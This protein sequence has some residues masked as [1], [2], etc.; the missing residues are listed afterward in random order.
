MRSVLVTGA[1][2]PLGSRLLEELRRREGVERIVGVEP[3]AT[4]NWIDGVELVAFDSDHRELFEFISIHEIDTVI[5]CALAPDR[6]GG[7]SEPAPARVIE[8]MRLGAAVAHEGSPVRAWVVA[9]SS[10]VY[11]ISSHAPLLHREDSALDVREGTLAA[12]LIEAEDY[13][14][15][16]AERNPHL[17]VSILRLQQLVGGGV[18]SPIATLLDQRILPAVIGYDAPMQVLAIDDA[19][20]ALI[21]AA[22]FELA[23][24]YNV[25]SAGVLRYSEARR[26]MKRR[27]LP[28]LPISAG[29]LGPLAQRVGIPHVPEGLL[30]RLLY[31]QA[32]DTS[33]LAA[34]G[35]DPEFDQPACLET[36][37]N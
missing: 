8:T 16:I 2:A 28:V 30:E 22:E 24:V 17:N 18:R 4:S 20:G 13:V 11:P 19:V 32:V 31:G 9:S 33:K 36:L 35:F 23:G 10:D 14:R 26:L 1:S 27:S 37:R 21:H 12:S 15:D 25:A 6:S 29:S 5:H 3:A 7:R 34:S